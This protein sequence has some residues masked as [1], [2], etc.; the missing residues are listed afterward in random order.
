MRT[1][2]PIGLTFNLRDCPRKGTLPRFL[3]TIYSYFDVVYQKYL[4]LV[5]GFFGVHIPRGKHPFPFRIRK[6]SPSGPMVVCS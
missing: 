1:N 5:V 4:I 2:Q 6:L 3:N